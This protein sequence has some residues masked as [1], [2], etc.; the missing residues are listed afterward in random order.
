MPGRDANLFGPQHGGGEG[1]QLAICN[2]NLAAASGGIFTVTGIIVIRNFVGNVTTVVGTATSLTLK[3]NAVQ[4]A[5]IVDITTI[6]TLT[7][8][9]RE[10]AT[11]TAL[12]KI[13][14]GGASLHAAPT[15]MLLGSA[16][17]VTT[18]NSVL[19]A[20]GTGVIQW[21]L[22]WFPLSG[23]AKVVAAQ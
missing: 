3:S 18:I 21:A 4:I 19:D 23:G 20:S 17:S 14:T 13:V 8:L 11:N 16:G 6:T 22:E 7:M 10:S 15:D 2:Q 12:T 5:A 9:M 1:F